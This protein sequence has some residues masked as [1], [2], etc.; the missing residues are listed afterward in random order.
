M[1]ALFVAAF[2]ASG[3]PGLFAPPFPSEDAPIRTA[4]P[5]L[6]AVDLELPL[7]LNGFYLG[8]ISARILPDGGVVV[9]GERLRALLSDRVDP[10]VLALLEQLPSGSASLAQLEGLGLVV[11]YDPAALTL[12][13]RLT[14]EQTGQTALTLR[15]AS[16]PSAELMA[17]AAEVAAG[18]S[19]VSR[20]AYVHES[21]FEPEGSQPFRADLN[22]FIAVGGFDGWALVGGGDYDADRREAWRRNAVTL[23]HDDYDQAIR[24]RAGDVRPRPEGFQVSPDILGLSVER[25]YATIQPFRNI[26]ASGRATFTLERPSVVTIEVNGVV[27]ATLSLVPGRY[28]VRDFPFTQGANAIRV[29]VEDEFGVREIAGFSTFADIELLGGGLDQFGVSAGVL[30]DPFDFEGGY[31]YTDD[32]V[33]TAHYARGLSDAVTVGGELEVG[34]D[35]ALVGVRAAWGTRLGLVAAQLAISK[36]DVDRAWAALARYRLPAVEYRTWLHEFDAQIEHRRAGFGSLGDVAGTAFNE[37]RIEARYLARKGS[38]FLGFTASHVESRVRSTFVSLTAG[39][40]WR[41]W[42]LS[43]TAQPWVA[44]SRERPDRFLFNITR[45]LGRH[46]SLR[47]RQ[48]TSP[49]EAQVEIQRFTARRVGD[50]GGRAAVG[51]IDGVHRL[52]G[53]VI[54]TAPRAEFDLSHR[55]ESQ[56][57]TTRIRRSISEARVGMG[58]GWADGHAAFGRPFGD[59][60]VIVEPHPALARRRAV[61]REGNGGPIAAVA[62]RW[63]PG[64]APLRRAYQA[65]SFSVEV[66]DLPLGYDLGSARIDAFGGPRS[67]F[68]H[69]VG[70]DA[71]NTVMAHLRDAAGAPVPLVSGELRRLDRAGTA[72]SAFFTNRTGRLVAERVAPGRYAVVL[73]DGRAAEDIVVPEAALGLVELPDIV[74]KG[75]QP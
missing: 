1:L 18:V 44:G 5:A 50:W 39:W 68:F 51:V 40:R 74:L 21:D 61:L 62:D 46:A 55:S 48:A 26:Q 22:G 15:P 57:D 27:T 11:G 25:D 45:R 59:G 41:E 10:G 53:D 17:G 14:P 66:D 16:P 42:T 24:Y 28:D 23:I 54:Y 4:P 7:S 56:R 49:Y 9:M 63:G 69:R 35:I 2:P 37:T 73:A 38:R 47:L 60:F 6:Q 12:D 31:A 58:L 71:A 36:R 65:E 19:L 52:D 20:A 30:R 64:L 70:S 8:D 3:E 67:G 43:A 34:P 29:L 13:V 33:L 72:A 32:P 75:T